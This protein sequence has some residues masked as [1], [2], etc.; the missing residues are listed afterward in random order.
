MQLIIVGLLA[1][2]IG[3]NRSLIEEILYRLRD[4]EAERRME[5]NGAAKTNG[6]VKTNGIEHEEARR[7][8]RVA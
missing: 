7:E 1:N 2:T 8:T 5:T 6:A 4:S 3:W